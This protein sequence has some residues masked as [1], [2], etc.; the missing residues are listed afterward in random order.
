MA[1]FATGDKAPDFNRAEPHGNN[2]KFAD[3]KEC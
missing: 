3:F 1:K 2:G